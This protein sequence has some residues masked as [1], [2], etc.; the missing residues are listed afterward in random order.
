[1]AEAATDR[2]PASEDK[3]L[4]DSDKDE[5]IL[6]LAR[7]R[8]TRALSAE[9]PNRLAA[10]DDL[11][12]KNG[13]QWPA[14]IRSSRT[15]E[16]RPCLTVNKMKTFVH[17]VTNQYRQN[18][19]AI[20]VSPVGDGSD[21]QTAQ[22]LQGLIKQIERQSNADV[23]YD[24]GLDSAASMGWGYWRILSEYEDDRSF[25]QDLRIMRI[26]N[27]LR[28]YL[29]PD[30]QEPDG[31]DAKW[32]FISDL[33]PRSEFQTLWPDADPI[34]W[35]QGT[36]GDEYYKDWST[37]T[38]VRIAEYFY[39]NTRKRKFLL[40]TDGQSVYDDELPADVIKTLRETKSIRK[41]REVLEKTLQWC[42]ITCHQILDK[43][44]W[45]GKWIPIVK[46]I[47]DEIDIEG[48]VTYAGIIRDAKD[49]QRM[50]N[51]WVT[52]KTE[53]IA[54]AP[55]APYIL[56]EGQVEGHE[57]RWQQANEKSFPYLLYKGTNIGGKQAPA[58]QRQ[59]LAGPP[60]GM[61]E[62]EMSA[63]QDMMAT[64]GIRFDATKGE[65]IPEESGKAI[66]MLRS[67]GELGSFHY[68]DNASRSLKFTGRQLI[69]LIPKFYDARR[70]VTIL[71]ED[72][73]EETV[74]IEPNLKAPHQTKPGIMGR[75]EKLYNPSLGK[76]DV[77]LSTGPSF[78]TKREEAREHMIKFMQAVPNSAPLVADL[79]AKNMDWPG[80]DE[81]AN[82][83]AAMLPPHLL[84]RDMNEFPPEAKALIGSLTQQL[85]QA[86]QQL[87][88]AA[89]QINN[90]DKD[91]AIEVDKIN[92]DFE[93]KMTKIAADM[94]AALMSAAEEQETRRSERDSQLAETVNRMAELL[95]QQEHER[96]MQREQPS[97]VQ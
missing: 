3:T 88:A 42:N 91:R 16:R 45:P 40:L 9:G 63:E 82:R 49:P 67:L 27:P 76:Y 55:K 44:T 30:H 62:A 10:L 41:E 48:K 61:I 37:Q 34:D 32:A 85:Q 23:A 12:F 90:E 24:T 54:L 81:I 36:F 78:Q 21:K 60:A 28:V 96:Q 73:S 68:T 43:N 59:Q 5:D 56:E 22:M 52:S 65:R 19:P 93:A 74:T 84:Q 8:F 39:F 87:K 71:R 46:V 69:D 64:T 2:F 38:H 79:V 83:F 47:G 25:N 11:R 66:G 92:K 86:Q 4:V 97:G 53:L 26:R 31:S 51:Y 95:M 72:D 70:V 77:A 35:E 7:K 50:K 20:K 1:M 15:I 17:Q 6:A 89:A 33:I 18:R 29:D 58:P 14:D 13:E 75:V 57:K 80:A 94:Q